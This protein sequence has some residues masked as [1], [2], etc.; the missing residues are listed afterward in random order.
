MANSI[1]MENAEKFIAALEAMP[2]RDFLKTMVFEASTFAQARAARRPAQMGA[3][4]G[5]SGLHSTGNTPTALRT[6]YQRG[7]GA[8][9]VPGR[10]VGSITGQTGRTRSSG[11]KR[12]ED[13]T[14]FKRGNKWLTERSSDSMQ[15]D[16]LTSASYAGYVKGGASDSPK[17]TRVMDARGW[18][19][20]D[21]V[22]KAVED[23]IGKVINNT[24]QRHY[25]QWFKKYG[26]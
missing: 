22:A 20:V 1:T 19:T 14:A 6:Y 17:Q 4:P 3:T 25:D 24:I 5:T 23:N 21:E 8:R 16:V 11:G 18:E 15:V 7:K 13:L 26:V 12:S 9:Y 2:T 10:R